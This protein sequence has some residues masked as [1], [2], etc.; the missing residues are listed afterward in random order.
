MLEGTPVTLPDAGSYRA[1][2]AAQRVYTASLTADSPQVRA[3][4]S[5]AAAN[6][7]GLPSFPLPLGDRTAS[8]VGAIDVVDLLDEKQGRRFEAKCRKA[9]ARFSGGVFACAA[10]AERQ[11]TG[12]ELISESRHSTIATRPPTPSPWDGSPAACR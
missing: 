11:L 10:L 12:A 4:H 6:G 2:C 1:Y 8:S 9:G 7:G 5:F 3:W